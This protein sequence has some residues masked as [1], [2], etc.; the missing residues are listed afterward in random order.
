MIQA[1]GDI[2]KD[3][4]KFIYEKQSRLREFI[5]LIKVVIEFIRGFRAF[6]FLD[7]CITIFGSARFDEKNKYYESARQ[8]AFHLARH[9]FV[10]LTGGGPGIMEA[11]NRGA[12]EAGG[13]SIGCNIVLPHEQKPNSY[14]DKWINIRYF[15]VRKV[16]LV[17][18]SRAFIILPGGYGTMDEF[19]ESLTLI[20]TGKMLPF[21]V[22]LFGKEYHEHLYK[23][24]ETMRKNHTIS[25]EDA[26]L[27]LFTD[28]MDE[29]IRFVVEHPATKPVKTRKKFHPFLWLGE[30]K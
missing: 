16:L 17:K 8:M 7:D 14:L 20:Q 29:A 27:F 18:Y 26:N 2:H 19:F 23:H 22:V 28:D 1:G 25:D 11:A 15:F 4:K 12:K 5:F 3:E 24:I 30:K 10:I 21:P 6:H 9:G 13:I